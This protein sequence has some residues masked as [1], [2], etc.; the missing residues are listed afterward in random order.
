MVWHLAPAS[1]EYKIKL[2]EQLWPLGEFPGMEE[3]KCRPG[4]QMGLCGN[5]EQA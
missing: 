4:I 3:E 2:R 1:L 5:M